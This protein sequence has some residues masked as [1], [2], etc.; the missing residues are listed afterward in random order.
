MRA[1]LLCL[2]AA[3]LLSGCGST[4]PLASCHG[5]V[6]ALNTG[7]WIPGPADVQPQPPIG[8]DK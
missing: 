6:F 4:E 1:K 5:P 2:S 3:L 8:R 7:R